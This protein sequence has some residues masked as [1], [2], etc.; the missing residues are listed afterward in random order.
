MASK[1]TS[2]V[3]RKGFIGFLSHLVDFKTIY[4]HFMALYGEVKRLGEVMSILYDYS[5]DQKE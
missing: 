1:P 4:V 3:S 2:Q 5:H